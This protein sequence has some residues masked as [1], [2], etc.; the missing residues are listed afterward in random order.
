MDTYIEQFAL[1]V[2]DRFVIQTESSPDGMS[3]FCRDLN[4]NLITSRV[5]T[6]KQLKNAALVNL[7]LADLKN[8]LLTPKDQPAIT[9]LPESLHPSA[10]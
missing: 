10:L 1:T 5:L 4:G 8:A 2:A 3:V 7:V 9:P 6:A